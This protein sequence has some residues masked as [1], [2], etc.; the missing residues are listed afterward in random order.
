MSTFKL[1]VICLERFF[2]NQQVEAITVTLSDGEI[3]VL[4]HHAPMIAA[5]T[6][7]AIKIKIDGKFRDAFCSEG[8]MEVRPDK[9]IIFAQACEWAD[10]IDVVR[11]KNAR[12]RALEK[13]RQER[14]IQEYKHNT[15]SL[16]RALAR[17]KISG[18]K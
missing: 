13:L 5:L 14:S 12:D 9:V 3:T 1:E 6:I 7:G 17:L 15:I 4:A 18:K 10:E 11:A 8:F 2:L 16:T